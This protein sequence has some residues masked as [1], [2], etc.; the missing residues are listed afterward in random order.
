LLKDGDFVRLEY[1]GFDD[2]GN[3]FDSTKG[4]VG[5]TLHGKEGPIL[6]VVG[7]YKLVKGLDDLVRTMKKGDENEASFGPDKGF[8]H[9]SKNLVKVMSV[10][11][12]EQHEVYPKPGTTIH[13]D[14]E[15]GRMFGVIKSFSGGRVMV[16]FNHPLA[17]KPVKYKV[18]L[19]D[20]LGSSEEKLKALIEDINLS[21]T[22]TIKDGEAIIELEKKGDD[23]ELRKAT[24]N[25][26]AKTFIPELKKIEIKEHKIS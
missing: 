20:V 16:D 11:D 17:D 9:R 2:N 3:L 10:K 4:E 13:V 1:E 15:Q 18:K 6:V 26:M 7:Y 14:T 21:G 22:V 19:V 8:G 23:F 12:F 5:K 25:A 24:I